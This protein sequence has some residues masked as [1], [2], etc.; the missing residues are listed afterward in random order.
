MASVPYKAQQPS[1]AVLNGKIHYFGG[2]YPNSGTPLTSHYVYNPTTDLWLPAADLPIARVIM[3]AAAING[4]LYAIS[5]QPE[6]AR[7]DEYNP[8]T[9]TW[10]TKNPLPDNNFWYSA[11]VVMN[12]EIY[13]IGGG[14]YTAPVS[15][16][17]KYNAL[18]DSWSNIAS[19]PLALHA[20]AG[21]ALGNLIYI[22]GGY[23]ATDLDQVRIFN[24]ATNSFV[25]TTPLPLARSYHELVCIDTCIYSVGGHSSGYPDM[26]KSLLRY[27]SPTQANVADVSVSQLIQIF[28]NPATHFLNIRND[29]NSA[30]RLKLYDAFGRPLIDQLVK[31]GEYT[32]DI[33]F[34]TSGLY[35]YSAQTIADGEFYTGK[36][37]IDR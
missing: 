4:K 5:G 32:I 14:G 31:E 29:Y 12:N 19:L 13:R 16:I 20:P 7:V 26:N 11:M 2:G 25:S 18:T 27:C 24:V 30:L 10:T 37:I 3:E 28:P 34:L 9:D 21:A 17:H 6:K 35:F 1:G 36:L 22:A 23:N 8:A 15:H 33:S